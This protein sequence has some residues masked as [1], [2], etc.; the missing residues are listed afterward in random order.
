MK[1]VKKYF[2][3]FSLFCYAG[4]SANELTVCASCEYPTIKE[5]VQLAQ[6]GDTLIIEPGTYFESDIQIEKPLTILGINYPVIDGQEK[7]YII[8]ITSDSVTIKGL[9]LKNIGRS[10]TT[11]FAAIRT[12]KVKYFHFEDIKLDNPFFG[13]HIEKS[14]NGVIKNNIIRGNAVSE[15]NSGNGIHLW[16]SSKIQILNNSI[17]NMRDGI[18]FEFV[19]H[20]IVRDNVS[21]NNIRYG[22]H[23]MFSN[24]DRYEK[25]LFE[26]N[27]AGVAVMFSKN[28]YMKYN[29]FRLNWGSASYGL[30]L[31]EINDAVI[32]HNQ[33]DQNTIGVNADGANRIV[34]ENNSFNNNGWAIR[35]L[36]ACYGNKIL[37]NNFLHNALDISYKGNMNGNIFDRNFWSEYTGYDLNKDNIGDV[38]YRPVK[39][40]SYVV[41]NTPE[42][43][44]L[45][46]SL[47]VDII[48]FSEKVSP[49]FTPDNLKDFNPLMKP[50]INN[51]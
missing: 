25:N 12:Y 33:F 13:F 6:S 11:D 9:S 7:S 37:Q 15:H 49:I 8:N 19:K 18:Y 4:L 27:G 45:L 51:D 21:R 34:F 2:L 1:I 41:N 47:F 39:L 50:V 17:E 16:H 42:T 36:G 10:Y 48:N 30:L 3:I 24:D 22:L 20:S 38:P 46:R 32:T 28:I 26:K 44:I 23:F 29:T 35:F 31:K 43:I 5:A 14:S 40:F